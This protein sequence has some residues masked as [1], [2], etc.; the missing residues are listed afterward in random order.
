[1]AAVGSL[2][3]RIMYPER[4]S[5][6]EK[7]SKNLFGRNYSNLTAVAPSAEFAAAGGLMAYSADPAS[8]YRT[9]ATFVD[10]ILKVASPPTFRSSCRPSSSW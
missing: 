7:Y 4:N 5:E 3:Q 6:K 10:N 9:A 1:M 2:G 8:V